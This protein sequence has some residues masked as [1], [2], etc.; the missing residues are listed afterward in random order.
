MRKTAVVVIAAGNW[1]QDNDKHPNWPANYG[2]EK[3][4]A[5]FMCVAVFDGRSGEMTT[6]L[7]QR[8]ANTAGITGELN[9]SGICQIF[10]LAADCGFDQIAKKRPTVAD[11]CKAQPKDQKRHAIFAAGVA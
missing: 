4:M 1:S 8:G 2:G 9:G 6:D 11:H 7:F 5:R 10:S 3:E